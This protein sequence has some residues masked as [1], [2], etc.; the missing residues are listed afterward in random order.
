MIDYI[1]DEEVHKAYKRGS[2]KYMEHFYL[3]AKKLDI[4]DFEEKNYKWVIGDEIVR[5]LQKDTSFTFKT[6]DTPSTLFGIPVHIDYTDPDKIEL[7]QSIFV[8]PGEN[9]LWKN[10]FCL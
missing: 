3:A 4:R 2:Y 9:G 7:W 8:T 10:V 6:K 5:D 1:F